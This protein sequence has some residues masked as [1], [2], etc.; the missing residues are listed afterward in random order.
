[1]AASL[2]E[3]E[4][5]YRDIE[6]RLGGQHSLADEHTRELEEQLRA[7]SAEVEAVRDMQQ[8]YRWGAG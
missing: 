6:A 1:M 8:K 7:M 5:L 3:R 2:E 4:R